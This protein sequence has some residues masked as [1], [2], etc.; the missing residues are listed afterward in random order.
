MNATAEPRGRSAS[1]RLVLFATVIVML[2]LAIFL[3][4]LVSLGRYRHS[5]ITSMSA[6]LGRPVYVGGMQMRL[7]PTPG[8]AM[9]DFTVEEDPAFGYEPAL[10]ADSVVASLRLSSLWRGRLEVSRISLDEASLNL[11]RNS[12]GQWSIGSILLRA[13]QIPN[14]P[15]AQRRPGATLRFPYIEA[16]DAR[17]NFKQGVEKKPFSLMNA[18]FS[19]WQAGGGEWRLRLD[20]QPVRTDLEL[21]LSDTGDL[22]LE[23]SLRRA[24]DLGD[25]PV[26]L[27]A[28]WS[29][30]QLGQVSRLLAG[31]DS[32][33]RGEL[34]ATAT[35][36]GNIGDL[37]LRSRLKIGNLR[38]QEFQP[39]TTVDLDATCQSQYRHATQTLGNITC[40]WPIAAGHLLLT[41]SVRGFAAPQAD[42]QFE[43]NHIPSSF[44]LAVLGLMRQRAQN[45]T[46]TGTINGSFR[47]ETGQTPSFSGEAAATPGSVSWPGTSLALPELHFVALPPPPLHRRKPPGSAARNALELQTFAIP[48]GEPEP[49]ELDARFTRAGFELHVTGDASVDRLLTQGANFGLLENSINAMEPKGRADLNIAAEGDWSPPLSGGGSGIA[50]SGVIHLQNAELRP[51]FLRAPVQVISADVSMAPEQVSWQ[52][53]ALRYAGM[54]MQGSLQFPALCTQPAPCGGTFALQAESLSA[55]AIEAAFAGRRQ[56]L[57]GQ[58]LEDALGGARLSPW[59]PLHG[60]IRCAAFELG[61]LPLSNAAAS[62][63]VGQDGLRIDSLD[64]AALGGVLHAAGSMRLQGGAPHWTLDVRLTSLRPA[65]AGTLFHEQWG[66]G[67]IDGETRLTLSGY[68]P[69]QLVSSASGEFRFTWQKGGFVAGALQNTATLEQF[70]RWSATGSIADGALTLTGGGIARGRRVAPVRGSISLDR[71]LD[72]TVQTRRGPI[73]IGGTLAH[74][75]LASIPAP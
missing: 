57:L 35:I 43:L 54:A 2:I 28:E 20:A 24:A 1:R 16:S 5:I 60:T 26:D 7:L 36:R 50:T 9:T 38:R 66:G 4:P 46:A 42:L 6:A 69:S 53:V 52:N 10:H 44:P 31:F 56:G 17:I 67:S 58:I 29:A 39:V 68:T 13:S 49:M 70:D 45:V 8:I 51:G 37:L 62:V 34:D 32:G 27:R 61:R 14:A 40:F 73:R 23:G 71:H 55:S 30:A 74:P 11:V 65:Q 64:A 25:M 15:T 75:V 41:G 19:M 3:P 18:E 72:L 63:A 12:A 59:P 47:I 48:F 22:R 33:W 21:H